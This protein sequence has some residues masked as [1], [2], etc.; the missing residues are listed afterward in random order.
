MSDLS[1]LRIDYGKE[2][3]TEAS[4]GK[5][6]FALLQGWV[7]LAVASKITD[8]NAMVV[9]SVDEA[10]FP[11]SRIVLLRYIKEG[12]LYFFTNYHSAKS[13]EL[14]A[15]GKAGVNFFWPTLEKQIRVSCTVEKAS[16]ADSDAYFQS[17]PRGSQIGAWAS[18]QSEEL[19]QREV[20]EQR[21][22][23]FA[24]QFEGQDVPRPEH[25]GGLKL[26]PVSFEFWQGRNSRLH[27]RI[28]F[29]K[30]D[31]TWVTKRLYP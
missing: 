23:Q 27:D 28:T 31:E 14:L 11:Q 16:V 25:W 21:V 30:Q 10:G 8:A 7:D 2:E 6:P 22:E 13:K 19:P 18:L 12:A 5:D 4:A 26:T 15:S 17:R 20:L 24:Q 1:K 29:Q 9:S 3:L